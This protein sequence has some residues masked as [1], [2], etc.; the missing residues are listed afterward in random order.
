MW[1]LFFVLVRERRDGSY[2]LGAG[3]IIQ[4]ILMNPEI[5]DRAPRI[6]T[7]QYEEQLCLQSL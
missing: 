6:D 4:E 3:F 1:Q 5:S 2:R 7:K